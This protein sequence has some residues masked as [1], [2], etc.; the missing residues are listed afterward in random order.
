MLIKAIARAIAAMRDAH[1]KVES[2]HLTEDIYREVAMEALRVL[3]P[4]YMPP[5]CD[6]PQICG[7]K[8]IQMPGKNGIGFGG[9]D[10]DA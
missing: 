1:V 8:I 2:V 7:V 6:E 4:G 10:D 5:E 3:G 9:K